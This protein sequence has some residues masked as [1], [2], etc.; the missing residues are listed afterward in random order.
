MYIKLQKHIVT[1]SSE[2]YR[3]ETASNSLFSIRLYKSGLL[4]LTIVIHRV[5]KGFEKDI[6]L[7]SQI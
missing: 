4:E 1:L 2:A 6:N 7:K 3:D 5:T